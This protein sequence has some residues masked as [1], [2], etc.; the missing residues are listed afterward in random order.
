MEVSLIILLHLLHLY[1]EKFII[2]YDIQ[3]SDFCFLRG[4]TGQLE[5]EK[6]NEKENNRN[7]NLYDPNDTSVISHSNW[8]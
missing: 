7:F 5:E 2:K 1:S 6:R 8:K 3:F 4:G